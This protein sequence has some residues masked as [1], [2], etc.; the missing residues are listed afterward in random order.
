MMNGQET[1]QGQKAQHKRERNAK[2]T[3]KNKATSQL[4]MVSFVDG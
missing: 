2:N 3:D 4:K 1:I